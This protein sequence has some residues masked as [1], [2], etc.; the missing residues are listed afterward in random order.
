MPV[1]HQ[2]RLI[3]RQLA[4]DTLALEYA[5]Y[6]MNLHQNNAVN[7]GQHEKENVLS[8]SGRAKGSDRK[9]EH[10]IRARIREAVNELR[11]LVGE[12]SELIRAD[13]DL[14]RHI[15]RSHVRADFL[16]QQQMSA[17]A[18]QSTVL[19]EMHAVLSQHTADLDDILQSVARFEELDSEARMTPVVPVNK[20]ITKD[21]IVNL[22]DGRKGRILSRGLRH[23]ELDGDDYR[24]LFGL[25]DDYLLWTADFAK[26]RAAVMKRNEVWTTRR[27]SKRGKSKK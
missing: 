27:V 16:A 14:I 15:Q 19:A 26:K 13:Q 20:A 22:I 5:R 21:G 10:K 3:D 12:Y 2:K 17:P 6:D 1:R 25:P 23:Y 8:D 9:A 11:Q 7:R 4:A 18:N 24:R